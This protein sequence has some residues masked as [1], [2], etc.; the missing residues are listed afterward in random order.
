MNPCLTY[1][2]AMEHRRSTRCG[3]TVARSTARRTSKPWMTQTNTCANQLV[4][5]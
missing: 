1:T 4:Q 2:I 3:T 5:R